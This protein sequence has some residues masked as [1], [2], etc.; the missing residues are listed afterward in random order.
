ML[1]SKGSENATFVCSMVYTELKVHETPFGA[2]QPTFVPYRHW[3]RV[4]QGIHTRPTIRTAHSG[5]PQRWAAFSG[6]FLFCKDSAV[7]E[8]WDRYGAQ[9]AIVNRLSGEGLQVEPLGLANFG[10]LGS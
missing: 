2:L 3:C 4:R 10:G 7:G 5:P 1:K 6:F 8:R 9:H